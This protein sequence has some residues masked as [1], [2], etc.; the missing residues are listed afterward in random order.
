MK[1]NYT[2]KNIKDDVLKC[3]QDNVGLSMLRLGDGEV[4]LLREI[5]DKIK[6]FSINQLGRELTKE[7]LNKTQNYLRDSVLYSNILGL[8]C[9]YHIEKNKLWENLLFYYKEIEVRYEKNW[10]KKEY[11]SI[12]SHMELLKNGDLFEILSKCQKIVIV[13]SRDIVDKLKEKFPNIKKIEFYQVPG[14]QKYEIQ[15][16]TKIDLFELIEEITKKLKSKN[17][18]GELLIYG[19]GPF[20]KQLGYE[21][22][23][24]NGV[25]LDLGSV[26]DLF[27]GKVT[28]GIGKGPN[29]FIEPKL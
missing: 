5:T 22:A 23:S 7:E 10:R 6:Q 21:F 18:G 15:K 14:E 8:P 20:G 28:R 16:N 29:S 25:S 19:V 12:D 27:V 17:R 4:I 9:S 3:L 26:F 11:C 1:I 2:S 24:M 13:S